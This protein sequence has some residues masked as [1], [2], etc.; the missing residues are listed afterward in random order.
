MKKIYALLFFL[1][2]AAYVANSQIPRPK[3]FA[4]SSSDPDLWKLRRYELVGGI[5]TTQFFG[6]IGGFSKGKNA[7]GFKDFSFNHTRYNFTVAMK[8]KITG[9]IAGRLNLS[10]GRFHATDERGSNELRGIESST[11]FFQPSLLCEYYII[12][13]K[14]E[15]SYIFQKG[16]RV[17]MLPLLSTLNLYT[18]TGIGGIAY[19]ANVTTSP[20]L[21]G[22]TKSG[23]FAAVLPAGV[24]VSMAYS[25]RV[26]FGVELTGH[27]AF[28][29]YLDGYTSIYSKSNDV[30]YFVLFSVSYKL[31]SGFGGLPSFRFK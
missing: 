22:T 25:G 1:I 26:N 4:P 17:V 5:G 24:G 20:Y 6:D 18:F 14:G 8:Y 9:S 12:K 2:C 15:S 11:T 16:R 10:A 23:G 27:Y 31:P 3:R 7:L 19:H 21:T 30:Y 29:D 13:S 28:T